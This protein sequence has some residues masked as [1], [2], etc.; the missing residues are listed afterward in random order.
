[1]GN[2]IEPDMDIVGP[3]IFGAENDSDPDPYYEYLPKGVNV[4][5]EDIENLE[6]FKKIMGDDL[7]K[8]IFKDVFKF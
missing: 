2:M 5:R 3:E 7:Y 4:S 8:E 6:A 1:M